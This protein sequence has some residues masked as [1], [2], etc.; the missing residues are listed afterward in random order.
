[1]NLIVIYYLKMEKV[2]VIEKNLKDFQ[3]MKDTSIIISSRH[4]FKSEIYLTKIKAP[5][6]I[7]IF[8][9]EI[10]DF[11][12]ALNIK[13]II[14]WYSNLDD[15]T[16][17][18]ITSF[19]NRELIRL[20]CNELIIDEF[21]KSKS[22]PKEEEE[23]KP[24]NKN[25][26]IHSDDK[27]ITQQLFDQTE[28][29]NEYSFVKN[30]E[31]QD[32]EN[33]EGTT[34]STENEKICS[35]KDDADTLIFN[36][37]SKELEECLNYFPKKESTIKP[38]IPKIIDN[39][40]NIILPDSNLLK[41]LSFCQ[42]LACTF[43]LLHFEY[44]VSTGKAYEMP[45]FKELREF[46][47]N[48]ELI[49]KGL[50]NNKVDVTNDIFSLNNS[51]FIAQ[52]CSYN[53]IKKFNTKG[54][55]F[56]SDDV[57]KSFINILKKLKKNNF[58]ESNTN[59]E[60][61]KI[62]CEKISYYSL[63]DLKNSEH[64]IYLEIRNDLKLNQN[65]DAFYMNIIYNSEKLREIKNQYLVKTKKLL[66]A[67][68]GQK[69][70]I[71]EYGSYATDL[72]TEFSDMDILIFDEEIKDERKYGKNLEE[73]FKKKDKNLANISFLKK[74][75]LIK[76]SYDVS[77]E[78]VLNEI[79]FSLKYL[80]EKKSDLNTIN[81]DI[82]FTND[83]IKVENTKET[84]KIIK[85][86]LEKYKQLRPVILYLKT[87]FRTQKAYSIYKGGI[88]SISLFCLTRNILV[89]YEK[90]HFDVNL[91]SNGL[92]LFYISEKFGHYNYIYGIDKDGYDFPLN[93]QEKR[94]HRFVIK[95][96]VDNGKNIAEGFHDPAKIIEKFKILFNH[97][98]E[99]RDIFLPLQ[100]LL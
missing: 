85:D 73:E 2:R 67:I 40:W 71:I 64:F 99:G 18:G 59:E 96:L 43:I 63:E 27:T 91:F 24:E 33:Y 23:Q 95:N 26:I 52:K 17:I 72:S 93:G 68:L 92:I 65:L 41:T 77:K 16:K 80:D 44:Y 10:K 56:N 90:N 7:S 88:N 38:I 78:K 62:L 82:T 34:K 11:E 35:L 53:Y 42:I 29:E 32:L 45:F 1:M 87:F 94:K 48:N 83:K 76:I 100:K 4:E 98:K 28:Q 15:Q 36:I 81:I 13:D 69:I 20:I 6:Y 74:N 8:F 3:S 22:P 9:Q 47:Q 21:K 5:Y 46:F 70:D 30:K 25:K 12:H 51:S 49:I 97:L 37:E 31:Y 39:T 57:D 61:L 19:N 84:I 75:N 60:K 79:N 14:S 50:L 55:E 54:Q 58:S 86:S 66:K 89:T